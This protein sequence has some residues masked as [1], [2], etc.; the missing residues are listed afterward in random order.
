MASAAP[1]EIKASEN[2]SGSCDI[3]IIS[4]ATSLS[5]KKNKKIIVKS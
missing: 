3:S 5:L 1:S 2:S 4:S